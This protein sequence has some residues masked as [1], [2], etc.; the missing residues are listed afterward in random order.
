MNWQTNFNPTLSLWTTHKPGHT[1]AT[2]HLTCVHIIPHAAAALLVAAQLN[3]LD[4]LP[5]TKILTAIRSKQTPP[6][7]TPQT[8]AS[9]VCLAL[10]PSPSVGGQGWGLPPNENTVTTPQPSSTSWTR[11]TGHATR[12]SSS[13]PPGGLT[14][15]HEEPVNH[16]Q[17]AAF[18][19]GLPLA[20]LWTHYRDALPPD[21]KSL[22][23]S[24]LTDL[25]LHLASKLKEDRSFYPN[26]Y[27]G[28]LIVLLL[29]AHA[30]GD[31]TTVQSILPRL[32]ALFSL[33]STNGWG[34]GEDISDIYSKILSDQ[35]S[36]L[37]FLT[38]NIPPATQ[39]AAL[40][41]LNHLLKIADFFHPGPRV[42]AI[43]TYDFLNSPPPG[44]TPQ[45]S[46]PGDLLPTSAS[47]ACLTPGNQ[48]STNSKN[49]PTTHPSST[50]STQDAGNRTQ[51][52]STS[53]TRDSSSPSPYRAS[54]RPWHTGETIPF[55]HVAP[56]GHLL[57]QKSWHQTVLPPVS[58]NP[59][60]PSISST[61]DARRATRDDSSPLPFPPNPEPR[62][63]PPSSIT[64]PLFD[65]GHGTSDARRSAA[66]ALRFPDFRIGCVSRFPI[67]PSAEHHDWGLS[68]QSMPVAFWQQSGAW[69]YL[70]WA[71]TNPQG[72]IGHPAIFSRYTD[73]SKIQKSLT[74]DITP[75]LTGETFS[76]LTPTTCLVLRRMPHI[77]ASW[78]TFSDRIRLIPPSPTA[79]WKLS[80]SANSSTLTLHFP[81]RS[82][83]ITYLNPWHPNLTPSLSSRSSPELPTLSPEPQPPLDFGP[84]VT[85]PHPTHPIKNLPGYTALWA[86]TFTSAP[87]PI[88][89]FTPAPHSN[90]LPRTP[91]Q[92][93]FKFHWP[94]PTHP[95]TL[96]LDPLT[97]NSWTSLET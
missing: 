77:P 15:Y 40:S 6:G 18:F 94:C 70:Q 92:A 13:S 43:R 55:K 45:T 16:D 61:R 33:Y 49:H 37:I 72:P 8:S 60:G 5:I 89:T 23:K 57:H 32:D 76:L 3:E 96:T 59:T 53:S 41:L 47:A 20:L 27:L 75:P 9:A 97:P 73:L 50:S 46:P 63:Q 34:W 52:D 1:P 24:I 28:D 31:Q 65:Q 62:T 48:N 19:T 83:Q 12:D 29:V 80:P 42:P 91:A 67:M 85:A 30:A 35:L 11:D 71:I 69:A 95:L 22:L 4:Q 86:I 90:H 93:A 78:S 88:P 21:A 87:Q 84:S 14:F 64:I 81:T 58:P 68:W 79:Q 2:L 51:D 26:A 17:N 10:P 66:T 25:G 36:I 54:I 7:P 44:V 74:P 56:I 38:P 39:N 82:I